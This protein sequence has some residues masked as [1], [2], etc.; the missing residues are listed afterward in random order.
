MLPG[1]NFVYVTSHGNLEVYMMENMDL[2]IDD[3]GSD[4]HNHKSVLMTSV[5]ASFTSTTYPPYNSSGVPPPNFVFTDSPEN[6]PV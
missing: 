4:P 3:N 6:Q 1:S 2:F 5:G